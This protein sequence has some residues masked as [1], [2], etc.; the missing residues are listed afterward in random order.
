MIHLRERSKPQS[1]GTQIPESGMVAQSEKSLQR[2]GPL[3]LHLFFDWGEQP[4]AFCSGVMTIIFNACYRWKHRS[5][6]KCHILLFT[7]VAFIVWGVHGEWR[8]GAQG[9]T[10]ERK[11][12]EDR[13]LL[14]AWN[15][16]STSHPFSHHTIRFQN[17]Q[18][19]VSP[20]PAHVRSKQTA[21]AQCTSASA[22]T[23][24][25]SVLKEITPAVPV[26]LMGRVSEQ[27]RGDKPPAAARSISRTLGSV[28]R[29]GASQGVEPSTAPKREHES[30][31]NPE[32]LLQP[33]QRQGPISRFHIIIS[34][35]IW[36]I[37][38]G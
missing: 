29:R 20:P 23:I 27:R 9:A 13:C 34:F 25:T 16:L 30:C 32:P 24:A 38:F 11:R 5:P 3:I 19:V 35:L 18:L 37:R 22:H 15:R 36:I 17:C 12:E 1:V 33:R 14:R 4:W 10:D 6:S 8:G 26:W 28:N 31:R 7:D 21:G 2:T